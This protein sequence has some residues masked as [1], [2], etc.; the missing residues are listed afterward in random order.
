MSASATGRKY[1]RRDPPDFDAVLNR[2]V[3]IREAWRE[4]ASRVSRPYTYETFRWS[5]RQ[6]YSTRKRNAKAPPQAERPTVDPSTADFVTSERV[7]HRRSI[8]KPEVLALRIGA[9]LRVRNGALE[10]SEILPRHLSSEGRLQI[11]VLS[12]REV[13]KGC[14]TH[15]ARMPK[16]IIL[17]E[18]GWSL[19]AEAVKFCLGHN[20]AL[21]SV[22]NRTSQ[23]EKGLIT[24]LAGDPIADPK[25]VRTQVNAHSVSIARAIVRRKI[26]VSAHVLGRGSKPVSEYLE[27]LSKAKTLEQVM[28]C[29]SDA[30]TSYWAARQCDI[31]TV[32]SRWPVEWDRFVVRNSTIGKRGPMHADHPVNALL[33]WSYAVAAGRLSAELFARGACLSVGFLHVDRPGRYSLAY[34]TL[35]LLRPVIDDKVFTFVTKT[36]FRMGDFLVAP[37]GRLRGEVRVSPALLK[38]FAPATYLPQSDV[39]NAATWMVE[40]IVA[41]SEK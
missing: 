16:A 11:T 24:V 29:E 14:Q 37:S 40:T 39:A 20:M 28:I 18:H 17:P 15:T 30:A 35:E 6:W 41:N 26:E 36:R 32:S 27:P 5:Y 2:N 4:Y 25:L 8:P 34:D 13:R 3:T 19:T 1:S 10:I 9:S 38:V 22:S 33:N 21:V 12:P 31:L 7:W 23:G